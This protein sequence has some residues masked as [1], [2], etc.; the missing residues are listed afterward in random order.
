VLVALP[1]WTGH[2]AG[3]RTGEANLGLTSRAGP[4]ERI[5]TMCSIEQLAHAEARERRVSI[6]RSLSVGKRGWQQRK[7]RSWL[8]AVTC[9]LQPERDWCRCTLIRR[10]WIGSDR[11]GE[12]SQRAR[13]KTAFPRRQRPFGSSFLAIGRPRQAPPIDPSRSRDQRAVVRRRAIMQLPDRRSHV[14]TYVNGGQA[15][16]ARGH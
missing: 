16:G 11:I 8:V 5:G 13:I 6:R 2:A 7:G 3:R 15:T 9:C 1:T 14:R 12:T 10:V 4:R